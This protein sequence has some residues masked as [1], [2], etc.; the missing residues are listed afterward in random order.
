MKHKILCLE[1]RR[2]KQKRLVTKMNLISTTLGK[3]G[4]MTTEPITRLSPIK[5]SKYFTEFQIF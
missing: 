3:A 5:A 4:Q 2:I 1:Q